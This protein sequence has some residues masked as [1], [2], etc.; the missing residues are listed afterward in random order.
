MESHTECR[1]LICYHE[2]DIAT[3][4]PKSESAEYELEC[5]ECLNN[6]S[7]SIEKIHRHEMVAVHP[8]YMRTGSMKG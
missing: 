6:D 2:V 1:C 5:P 7:D 4:S 8:R 3:F